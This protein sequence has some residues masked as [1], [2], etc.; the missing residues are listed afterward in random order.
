MLPSKFEKLPDEII[1]EICLYL[2]PFEIINGFG[3]LNTRLNR[4][5]SQFRRNADIHHLTFDQYQRWYSHL[6]PDTA[7]YIINL[8][9][10]NWNSPGQICRFNKSTENYTSLYNLLPNLK[11]LRLID[12]SN[13]D[14]DILPKLAMID[15]ILID[16]DGLKPLLQTT[17]HLLDYYLFCSSFSF[18]EIRLW[19]GEG[20][21]RLQHSAKL[22]VNPCLE[23]L[24]IV[25][26]HVDDLI[27]L[28]K[29]APNLIKLYVEISAFSSSKSY[30]YVTYAIMPKKLIDFHIQTN[31][32]KALTFEGLFIIMIH[33]PTIKR[34]SFD[35]ETYDIDYGDGLCWL[36]LISRLP[37]LKSLCFRIR[38]WIGTGIKSI[39]INPFIESFERA[40]LP[41]VCYADKRVIY[42]DTIPYDMHEFKTNTCVTT[43]PTVKYAK[44]T[45]E[46]LY[47]R[48]PHGVQSLLLCTRHEQTSIDDWLYVLNRFPYIRALE[49]T[50]VNII[51]QT[52]LNE[53]LR[54]PRLI[55]LRY[56][57]STRC[58]I[59]IPFFLL[60]VANS[61][62]SPA[63][64]ALTVMY[65]DIIHLCKRLSN[66]TFHRLQELWLFGSDTDGRIIVKDIDL[67]L[68][69]FP[70]LHHLSFVMH[71]SR[72]LNRNLEKIIEMILLTLP[73]LI[74]F[75]LICRRGSLQLP[76]LGDNDKRKTWIRRVCGLNDNEEIYW[77]INKKEISIWK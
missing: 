24:T 72:C 10:S 26:A 58:E 37:N 32:Q 71:S 40:N 50:A 77:V 41:I 63:L 60:L 59:N 28:F 14:I 17:K 67:L 38:I 1:L 69:A 56:V 64:R 47:R 35:I 74:S 22:R 73:N 70:N 61:N 33:I 16:I 46:E 45:D 9:L 75:R 13:E 51:E 23:Q 76:I 2:R 34:L 54:L 15:K 36:L 20:G 25:V 19:I 43:S 31:A 27:L 7:E 5:I 57:R 49:L 42:I 11:Q 29:R 62:V 39:D 48:R 66:F 3:Q 4:T 6:L 52:N 30:E 18:K 55:A 68:S 53:Q 8:V 44:T 12:F 21:I 65:G